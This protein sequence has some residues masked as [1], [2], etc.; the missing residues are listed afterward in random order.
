MSPFQGINCICSW[1]L[2]HDQCSGRQR[3]VNSHTGTKTTWA[4][5]IPHLL[6]PECDA[7]S[8]RYYH[9]C[10]VLWRQETAEAQ[11]IDKGVYRAEDRLPQIPAS[12]F[13]L[14]AGEMTPSIIGLL[15]SQSRHWFTSLSRGG[16]CPQSAKSLEISCIICA[17][18]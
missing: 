12:S 14:S 11:Y 16:N 7:S 17:D 3:G 5:K 15:R 4:C 2:G 10:C 8:R 1:Y 13:R 9:Q 18:R 6:T